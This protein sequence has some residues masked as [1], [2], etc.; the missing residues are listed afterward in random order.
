MVHKSCS[1]YLAARLFLGLPFFLCA[2]SILLTLL[3]GKVGQ[4]A[5]YNFCNLD[6]DIP[7]EGSNQKMEGNLQTPLVSDGIVR[8]IKFS[9][10]TFEEIVCLPFFL[11][12]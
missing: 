11:D 6:A 3:E 10:A 9:V 8:G 7:C 12:S 4:P 1:A 2:S 5:Y